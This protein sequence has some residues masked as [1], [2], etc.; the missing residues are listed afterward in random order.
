MALLRYLLLASLLV[1]GQLGAVAHTIDDYAQR[2]HDLGA[3][4]ELVCKTCLLY[5]VFSAGAPASVP[6]GRPPA[7]PALPAATAVAPAP[8][9]PLLLAFHSRAP[10]ASFSPW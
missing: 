1:F 10:P 8:A 6:A 9:T 5:S 2:D 7:A 4:G 3:T